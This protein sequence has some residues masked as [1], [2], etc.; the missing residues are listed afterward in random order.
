[1]TYPPVGEEAIRAALEEGVGGGAFPGA[2][3][4]IAHRHLPLGAIS[5]GDARDD[6]IFDLASLTKPMAVGTLCIRGLSEGWLALDETIAPVGGQ[7]FTVRALLGHRSGL[8]AWR[9][10]AAAADTRLGTWRPGSPETH[11]A[12]DEAIAEA[13]A[14]ANPAQGAVYSDL[15]FILLARHLERRLGRS[16]RELIDGYRPLDQPGAPE[17]FAP[18]GVCP[19]RGRRLYG[20]VNDIN[21]WVMGGAAGHAGLFANAATV[22]QWA[23][24]LSR[25]AAGLPGIA[26]RQ[27]PD[28]GVVRALWDAEH[29]AD[30]DTWVLGWDTPSPGPSTAGTRASPT[31]VGHLGFTGTSVWIDRD[32]ALV[33]VLLTNRVDLGPDSGPKIRTFRTSFHDAVRSALNL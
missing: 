9:D 15:G 24:D 33:V 32:Q 4:W 20:E 18:T 22:G 7:R 21:T 23:L 29:R 8:P 10:L 19:R 2:T 11:A 31:T 12:V 30:G 6:T 13:A 27:A 1:M 25:A 16:L 3:A 14:D 28:G 5:A 17:Q 26:G